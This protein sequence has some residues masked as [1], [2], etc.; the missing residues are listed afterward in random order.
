MKIVK[1]KKVFGFSKKVKDRAFICAMLALPVIGFLVFYLYVN[2]DSLLLS[3]Q[4]QEGNEIH[5]GIDNFVTLISDFSSSSTSKDLINALSNTL[6]YFF[7]GLLITVPASLAFCFF[8]YK[9]IKGYKIFR[10]LFYLPSIISASV[11]VALFRYFI[12]VNGPVAELIENFSLGKLPPLL[13]MKTK[14]TD[15]IIFYTVFFGVGG[16]LIL[17]S[18]AMSHIEESI[19]EAA[20]IDGAGMWTEMIKI[21][22]PLIWPTLSTVLLF[23]FVG[24]FNSSG[25]ILLFTPQAE[26]FDTYTISYWIYRQVEYN[27]SL[28]YPSA[29]GLFFTCIGVPI[30]LFMKW[31]LTRFFDNG[32]EGV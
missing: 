24:L 7:S 20:K 4:V 22:I 30:A 5:W 29:V 1:N 2:F 3:F 26:N 6:K 25:P 21:V 18:G 8:L 31:L 27:K 16:N 12:A 14:A 23:Q 13:T 15:T 11:L 19:V 9:K 28:Y 32:D 10:V 17:F